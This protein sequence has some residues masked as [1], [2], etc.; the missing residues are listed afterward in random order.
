MCASVCMLI[1]M[2]AIEISNSHFRCLQ[3]VFSCIDYGS[4]SLLFLRLLKPFMFNDPFQTLL[5]CSVLLTVIADISSTIML[6]CF[7]FSH[8]YCIKV[9]LQLL[10]V[11]P[12]SIEGACCNSFFEQIFIRFKYSTKCSFKKKPGSPIL[13]TLISTTTT[14]D[15]IPLPTKITQYS[16]VDY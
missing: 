11:R 6:N 15:S 13:T 8:C 14:T 16:F 1:T 2:A 7:E 3:I 10:R 4:S 9:M 12:R 5:L